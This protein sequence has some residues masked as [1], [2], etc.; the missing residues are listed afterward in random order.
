MNQRKA[1]AA[2]LLLAGVASLFVAKYAMRVTPHYA[3]LTVCHF[4]G[5][6]G[7]A[8]L[9]CRQKWGLFGSKRLFAAALVAVLGA[10]LAVQYHFNPEQLR[11]DRWSALHYPIRNLLSGEFPYLAQ[12]HLGGSASPFPMWQLFHIP[13]YLLGNVGLSEMF[14]FLLFILSVRIRFGVRQGFLALVLGALTLNIWYEVAVR[15]DMI[16]NF[17]LLAAFVNLLFFKGIRFA[18]HTILLSF[19]SGLWLSTRLNTVFPLVILFFPAWLSLPIG[20]KGA[21]ILTALFALVLTFVPLMLWDAHT[22]F[23]HE[24]SPFVLQTRQGHVL[25]PLLMLLLAVVFGMAWRGSE[26]RYHFLTGL[27][28]LLVPV[29]TYG[30]TMLLASEPL[31][32]F[33]SWCDITYL[34]AAIP[35]LITS[36]CAGRSADACAVR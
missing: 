12:T 2:I 8:W 30:H 27:L 34:D 17:L 4:C 26:A 23:Y 36:L 16:S 5:Y 28:L 3:W 11:V 21:A 20:K 9:L 32:I 25:D 18:R 10:M 29:I 22:L 33:D 35:F 24:Y 13:F 15:S 31:N 6:V 1:I 7:A 14:T 19:V